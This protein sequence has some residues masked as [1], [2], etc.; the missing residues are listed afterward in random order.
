MLQLG[1]RS[2]KSEQTSLTRSLGTSKSFW[3]PPQSEM[4]KRNII[5]VPSSNPA[6]AND[7][8]ASREVRKRSHEDLFN[9]VG[10][11]GT[12][13]CLQGFLS[14]HSRAEQSPPPSVL[15][16]KHTTSFSTVCGGFIRLSLKVLSLVLCLHLHFCGNRH[17]S[18]S[19]FSNFLQTQCSNVTCLLLPPASK[20]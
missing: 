9:P 18:S 4:T 11:S 5:D 14:L 16:E 12:W 2:L 3:G 15:K 19:C 1:Y 10:L 8:N 7:V 6:D 13:F 17:L 20:E